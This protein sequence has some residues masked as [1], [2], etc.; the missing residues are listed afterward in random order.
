[1]HT[2]LRTTAATDTVEELNLERIRLLSQL[3]SCG[4]LE[5]LLAHRFR[6][7]LADYRDWPE[8]IDRAVTAQHTFQWDGPAAPTLMLTAGVLNDIGIG[9]DQ[10]TKMLAL[11]DGSLKALAAHYLLAGNVDIDEAC[12]HRLVATGTA[13]ALMI[14]SAFVHSLP[15]EMH[16]T[17]ASMLDPYLD[18][19]DAESLEA[20]AA[21]VGAAEHLDADT[22][23]RLAWRVHRALLAQGLDQAALHW[24][25][26]TAWRR[27]LLPRAETGDFLEEHT[28][29]LA[30][31]ANDRGMLTLL[32]S[33][34]VLLDAPAVKPIT[35]APAARRQ[36][37][38]LAA[39]TDP[40]GVAGHRFV[41][42][43][44]SAGLYEELAFVQQVAFD[45]YNL[46]TGI[47]HSHGMH[48][49]IEVRLAA[50]AITA[51]GYLTRLKAKDDPGYNPK[52]DM[53]EVSLMDL[54]VFGSHPSL[55]RARII[56]LG[57]WSV[58][59]LLDALPSE[60]PILLAALKNIV[61][62]WLPGS[63]QEAD[64]R[65]RNIAHRLLR[66]TAE[67]P[68]TPQTRGVLTELRLSI[69]DR[70]G[71]YVSC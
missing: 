45:T 62:H 1:M 65:R 25:W 13:K 59:P 69:E 29:R 10:W 54:E 5:T 11:E 20:V 31:A 39:R 28:E 52:E 51:V 24:P 67:M 33:A 44:A 48:G 21:L 42:L 68:L 60:D 22:G 8:L 17:L 23:R 15:Q 55:T 36:L 66:A 56:S 57:Y 26:A 49:S 40:S 41:L 30:D 46:S 12:L 38:T 16:E 32:G 50:H 14:A 34:D 18:D 9:A 61:H 3:A 71:R 4:Q 6:V 58:E 7:G 27:A 47:R 43:A 2:L 53:D 64:A 63:P 37:V 70:L 19:L 35:L